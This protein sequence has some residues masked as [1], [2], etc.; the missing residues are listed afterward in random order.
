MT[1]EA[2]A[3]LRT[4]SAFLKSAD[5]GGMGIVSLGSLCLT[6]AFWDAVFLR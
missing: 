5:A 2:V 3:A 6:W 4:L 1:W